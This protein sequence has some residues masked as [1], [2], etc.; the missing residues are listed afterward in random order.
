MKARVYDSVEQMLSL[1]GLAAVAGGPVETV[2]RSPMDVE[3]YSANTLERITARR[4]DQTLNFVL[5]R[6]FPEHD[7]IMRLTHDTEV[8]EVALFRGNVYQ[9]VPDLAIVPVVAAARDGKSWAS[10]MVDI[11]DSLL[12]SSKP[13]ETAQLKRCLDHLAAIHA[14]FM[15]D[16]SLL[17]PSLGLSSLRDFIL[18]FSPTIIKREVDQ[19]RTHPVL[20]WSLRGWEIFDAMAMPAAVRMV[21]KV[22]QDLRPLLR[23]LARAP[24]TLVHGD[25][26]VANLGMWTP[27]PIPMPAAPVALAADGSA[28]PEAAAPTAPVMFQPEPRTIILDWQD[29]TFGSPLLDIAYFLAINSALLP[30][31]K[32]DTIQMYKDSL[33][34]FGY[35]YQPH[36]WARDLEVGLLAGG[37]M[38]LVWQK[39]LGTESDDPATR[40]RE[41][42]EVE[43]WSE[44]I[45][46]GGRWL[47]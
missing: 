43:W 17:H 15:E 36:A 28:M 10:L 27:P 20:E 42:A 14:R 39:A 30:V 31:S 7:W 35:A 13:L 45:I 3:H 38:R 19:G 44:Q 46:R 1:E 37:A 18:I 11:S 25:Y 33:A 2:E 5:K 9:R 23:A 24:R 22:Q 40:E 41:K 12:P 4:G 34:S 16:E 26:K 29:A 8:R 21:K 32:E 6:F 47:T